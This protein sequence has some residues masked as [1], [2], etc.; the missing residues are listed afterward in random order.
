MLSIDEQANTLEAELCG[1]DDDQLPRR[2]QQRKIIHRLHGEQGDAPR[3]DYRRHDGLQS[4][5]R[6]DAHLDGDLRDDGEASWLDVDTTTVEASSTPG[7]LEAPKQGSAA[8]AAFTSAIATASK[9]GVKSA[10]SPSTAAIAEAAPA[11]SS[12]SKTKNAPPEAT[13]VYFKR[14]GD[15]DLSPKTK[16]PCSEAA[17]LE[18]ICRVGTRERG[19]DGSMVSPTVELQVKNRRAVVGEG[20]SVL[21]PLG[22]N[23][24]ERGGQSVLFEPLSP[25][26]V[27]MVSYAQVKTRGR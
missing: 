16:T 11:T 14:G 6:Q 26:H 25:L 7:F 21:S 13:N 23:K 20:E 19:A 2:G 10:T 1:R 8:V 3:R 5:S 22:V 12:W 18:Q 15:S 24:L 17:K 9:I 27:V 4:G